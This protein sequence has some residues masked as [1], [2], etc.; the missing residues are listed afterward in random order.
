MRENQSGGLFYMNAKSIAL[1]RDFALKSGHYSKAR[2]NRFADDTDAMDGRGSDDG[3]S[4]TLSITLH[5]TQR[6][7]SAQITSAEFLLHQSV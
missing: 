6:Q 4:S 7:L 1:L 2:R 5:S 3:L